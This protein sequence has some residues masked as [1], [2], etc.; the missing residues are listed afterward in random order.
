MAPNED[1]CSTVSNG[2]K[3]IRAVE[4][5]NA[6]AAFQ[7]QRSMWARLLCKRIT[8][9]ED[10]QPSRSHALARWPSELP[11]PSSSAIA[12]LSDKPVV[13]GELPRQAPAALCYRQA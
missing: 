1:Q 11:M 6:S 3:Q 8:K 10:L 9:V 13:M 5:H 7:S 2:L 12:L 4:C